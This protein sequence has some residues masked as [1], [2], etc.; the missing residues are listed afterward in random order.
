MSGGTLIFGKSLIGGLFGAKNFEKARETHLPLIFDDPKKSLVPPAPP[1][2]NKPSLR[3]G[4]LFM[5]GGG[6][7]F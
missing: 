7:R 1:I 4:S 5:G 2:N 3:D 6:R